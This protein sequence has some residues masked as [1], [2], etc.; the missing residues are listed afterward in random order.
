MG[1]LTELKGNLVQLD[2]CRDDS[3]WGVN[4][5]NEAFILDGDEF[6]T[7]DEKKMK[8]I[9][10]GAAGVLAVTRDGQI[11][12]REGVTA[13]NKK[14]IDWKPIAGSAGKDANL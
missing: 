7:V 4:G 12:N 9:S 8:H 2:V 13:G 5:N 11:D 6:K 10:C 14:G 3:V 1:V